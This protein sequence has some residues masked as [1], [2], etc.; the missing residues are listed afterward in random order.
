M[1]AM[2]ISSPAGVF[3]TPPGPTTTAGRQVP[4]FKRLLHSPGRGSCHKGPNPMAGVLQ[5]PRKW[6]KPEHKAVGPCD[7]SVHK[8]ET[9]MT[10]VM[11]NTLSVVPER[12]RR[13]N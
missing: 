11:P 5:I 6:G 3:N 13:G 10:F 9:C 12:F 2:L 8:P 7:L 4:G 1:G